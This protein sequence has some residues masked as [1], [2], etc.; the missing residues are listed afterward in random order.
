MSDK[1]KQSARDPQVGFECA[2]EVTEL[3]NCVA[4]KRYNELK[5]VPILK[6]LRACIEK[7]VRALCPGVKHASD[8]R[9][10][11]VCDAAASPLMLCACAESGGLHHP[12]ADPGGR[13]CGSRGRWRACVVA[14]LQQLSTGLSEASQPASNGDHSASGCDTHD[15]VPTR[16]SMAQLFP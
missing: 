13:C 14:H 16:S 4:A 9:A 8:G 3:L 7:K 12:A 15:V 1:P 6:A 2:L 5:C 11:P 10:S